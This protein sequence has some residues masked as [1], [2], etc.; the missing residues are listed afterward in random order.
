MTYELYYW[1]GLQGRGEF[2]RLAL[3]EAGADYVDVARGERGTAKMMD[4]MHGKHGYDMP[5]AP[6]FLKDGDLIVSHV[7]NI[8]N[9]LGPKLDLVPKDEKS[10]LFAH[11]L[12]LTITD[13]LAEVH[14]T[15]H[16]I[17]TADYYE[18]QRQEAKARSKAFLK[19]RVPKFI[20]YFDRI[21]AANPTKSGN[22]VGDTLSYAD[23]SL[24]QLAKGLAYAFPHAMKN[25]DSDYP[26]VAKLRDAVAKRPNIEA[27]LK[28][29]RRLAFNESG[30]FRHYPDLDQDPA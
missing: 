28:S 8:L 12:Q 6:P 13:F 23:L 15:H 26:H 24:F 17:S 25:F 7:A 3:E 21:I 10:R 18:D 27:Y 20:G 16:P 22:A 30:I 9:Y 14:D 2:V 5:F 1:D 29:K 19:H 11:G 4:Y